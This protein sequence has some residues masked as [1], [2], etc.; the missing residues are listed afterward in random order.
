VADAS[1]L[2][3]LRRRVQKDPASL[4]FAQL[5]EECRRAGQLEEAIDVARAGL[6]IHPAYLSVRVTLGRALFALNRLEDAERELQAVV[7]RAPENLAAVRGLAEVLNRRGATAEALV[8][9]RAA[10]SLAPGDSAL[11]ETVNE[12][13]PQYDPMIES[14]RQRA[15]RTIT[16]LT[17]WLEAVHGSRSDRRA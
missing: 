7:A 16:A 1:R 13:T 12:L 17:R 8:H 9:Y 14:R 5:A 6:A 2:D 11:E 3:D 4:A 10:L 15:A